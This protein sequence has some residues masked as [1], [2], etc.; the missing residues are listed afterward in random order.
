M[1]WINRARAGTA[2][3]VVRQPSSL[4][5]VAPAASTARA[6]ATRGAR[7]PLGRL[8]FS[9]LGLPGQAGV[10]REG[11]TGRQPGRGSRGLARLRPYSQGVS[12]TRTVTRFYDLLNAQ[13][14]PAHPLQLEAVP[15]CRFRGPR[16]SAGV[17][18][19]V[20]RRRQ[21]LPEPAGY[22]VWDSRRDADIRTNHTAGMGCTGAP[23]PLE[24]QHFDRFAQDP[25]LCRRLY[26]PGNA[27]A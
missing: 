4:A 16:H 2:A 26:T 6:P 11:Q 14:D 18:L 15:V 9:G 5:S 17:R 22:A 13:S 1:S 7:R 21:H 10:A 27:L 23:D 24:Q 25:L 8:G 19:P 20:V 3:L 12:W